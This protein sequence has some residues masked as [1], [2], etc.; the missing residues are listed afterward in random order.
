VIAFSIVRHRLDEETFRKS[1]NSQLSCNQ[2]LRVDRR[3]V[4]GLIARNLDQEI[5]NSDIGKVNIEPK[6]QFRKDQVSRHLKEKLVSI[7]SLAHYC[8]VSG[9]EMA[10]LGTKIKPICSSV[11]LVPV[12][13]L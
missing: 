7:C 10:S 9:G 1:N 2:L 5:N 11:S 8:Y 12:I 6:A 13:V 4:V 3:S